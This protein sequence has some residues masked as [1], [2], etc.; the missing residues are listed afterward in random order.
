MNASP[1]SP[2]KL[3]HHFY[4]EDTPLRRLLLRH[5]LQVR[6]KALELAAG[7]TLP[8][9]LSV[10][11]DGALLH[12]IGVGRCHAPGILCM[13]EE[14]YLRHG[15]IGGE[16]LRGWGREHGFLDAM[17]P[18][19]CICERHTGTGLT[20]EEILRQG[21]PL[22]PRDF[23]P[24]TPEEKLVCLADKFFSKSG[25]MEERSLAQ[26]FASLKKFGPETQARLQEFCLLFRLPV[27]S[28][29]APRP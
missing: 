8:L 10:V 22:P 28:L 16:M 25:D 14:P 6:D 18:L 5:S 19:A 24:R 20:R 15:L 2:E 13:G 11:R 21:L 3:F 4:P 29:E 9:D 17:E 7:A 26:V 23:L 1:F 27:P 12:D